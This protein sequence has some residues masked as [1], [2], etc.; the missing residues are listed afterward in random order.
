MFAFLRGVLYPKVQK[1]CVLHV[2]G[3]SKQQQEIHVQDLAVVASDEGV[4]R[5]CFISDT[6]LSHHSITPS[7]PGTFSVVRSSFSLNSVAREP[8]GDLIFQAASSKNDD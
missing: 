5:I 8:V 4:H 1:G 7:I 6:H 2:N 3:A